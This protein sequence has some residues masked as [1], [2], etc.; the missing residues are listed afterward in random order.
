MGAGMFLGGY[1]GPVLIRHV[2]V[3]PLRI[4]VAF[5]AFG[6]AG[7]LFYTAYF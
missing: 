1:L 4:I 5:A 7:Y 3:R 6:L 2:P